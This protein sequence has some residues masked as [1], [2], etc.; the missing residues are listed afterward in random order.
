MSLRRKWLF[1]SALTLIML[2]CLAYINRG[3]IVLKLIDIVSERRLQVGPNQDIVWQTGPDPESRAPDA[4]PPNIVL[5]LTDDLGWNDLTI[6][7][8]LAGGTVPTPHID[9]IAQTGVNFTNAYAASATCAPSR[10]AL[11]TG[12]YGTRFGFEF[13][14]TPDSISQFASLMPGNS[15]RLRRS[16][17]NTDAESI[18]YEEMGVP[19]SEIMISEVLSGAGYHT[20]QIGKWQMGRANGM[21]AVEQGF[22]ESLLLASGLYLPED[23]P[24][25]VNSKQEFDPVDRLFWAAMK[26]AAQYSAQGSEPT[27]NFEPVGY[28]TDYYTDQAVEVIEAN[29]DR[30]F[31]LYLSYFA[32]H[33]P[34]QAKKED[35][36][37]LSHIGLHRERVYGAMI[38]SLDRGVGQVL[39]AL[40]DNGLDENTIVIFT[41]DNG[42]AGYVGLPDINAP[43]RGWKASFFNGGIRVPLFMRWPSR[44]PS[45]T[46]VQDPVHHFD[47]YSTAAQAAAAD[48]PSD[49]K[50]DGVDLLPFV[51]GKAQGVPHDALFWRSGTTEAAMVG[52]WMLITSDPPGRDW[53]FDLSVDPQQ[54]HDLSASNPDK[55]QELKDAL[56]AHNEEQEPSSWP[57]RVSVP[58]TIDK[59]LSRPEASGDEFIYWSN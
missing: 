1:G 29:K 2:G 55:V 25:V 16:I 34:L 39:Q 11:L 46:I 35:Y 28:L 27:G 18:P 13:T 8:G 56:A 30:P 31:F 43:Y 14:P 10:A 40:E 38:R 57:S 26:Y 33:T 32:P 22:N 23:H 52:N 24:D 3:V 12:R 54:K 49:R 51:T 58:I 42:G 4:R 44:V 20:V 50:M 5:I 36:D 59:D 21:S 19:A 45:G 37:A 47:I 53:L 6:N 41:S 7:G 9:S 17:M 48:L 15:D